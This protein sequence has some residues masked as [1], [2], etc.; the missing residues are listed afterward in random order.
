MTIPSDPS[1]PAD[2]DYIFMLHDQSFP[3]N[4]IKIGIT[5]D[6]IAHLKR[7]NKGSHYIALF[8]CPYN[9]YLHDIMFSKFRSTLTPRP[10]LGPACFEAMDV[11]VAKT[12]FVRTCTTIEELC[13][14]VPPLPSPAPAS[15]SAPKPTQ[16]PRAYHPF[17]PIHQVRPSSVRAISRPLMTT[18]HAIARPSLM[19][20]HV[21]TS[22]F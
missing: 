20:A 1:H 18:Q 21:R 2:R 11:G 15:F 17:H 5:R 10:D 14:R 16:R 13:V 4:I 8:S 7:H 3:S 22:K 12:E 6:P 19:H 9:G